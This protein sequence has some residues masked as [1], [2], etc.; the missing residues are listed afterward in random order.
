MP[1]E[2]GEVHIVLS[3]SEYSK[4]IE[5]S[6]NSKPKSSVTG[7]LN[8]LVRN[9]LKSTTKEHLENGN[10]IEDVWPIYV[11]TTQSNRD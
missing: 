10:K 9:H 1:R 2:G 6:R 8:T 5:L 4:L 11:L 7:Y 3:D